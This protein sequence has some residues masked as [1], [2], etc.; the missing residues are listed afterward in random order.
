MFKKV[1]DCQQHFHIPLGWLVKL[2]A[3]ENKQVYFMAIGETYYNSAP[4][5]I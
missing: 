3:Q 5:K 1:N 2:D 4:K